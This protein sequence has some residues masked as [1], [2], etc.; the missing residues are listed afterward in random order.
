MNLQGDVWVHTE[1]RQLLVEDL[2]PLLTESPTGAVESDLATAPL[3]LPRPSDVQNC[4][5]TR[6][7]EERTR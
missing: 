5:D 2:D 7:N 3:L 1:Q 6:Q 4:G